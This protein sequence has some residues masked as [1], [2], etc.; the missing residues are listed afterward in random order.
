[1]L[2]MVEGTQTT[3]REPESVSRFFAKEFL[4]F[5]SDLL[6]GLC[7]VGTNHPEAGSS[8][9]HRKSA[10]AGESLTKIR[11]PQKEPAVC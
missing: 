6:E 9:S 8:Q 11:N 4:T 3:E 7:F 2:R 1:M 10:A 5:V